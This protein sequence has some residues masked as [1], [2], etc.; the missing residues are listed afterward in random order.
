MRLRVESVD[1]ARG[2]V[3]RLQTRGARV[4]VISGEVR[5]A[6]D[7]VWSSTPAV[8]ELSSEPG[9]VALTSE[10][11]PGLQVEIVPMSGAR[12]P[13]LVGSGRMLTVLRVE[14]AGQVRLVTGGLSTRQR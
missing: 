8:L 6:G 9:E 5:L 14:H 4:R 7:T 3:F 12:V 13:R 10:A 1:S 11:G 2:A